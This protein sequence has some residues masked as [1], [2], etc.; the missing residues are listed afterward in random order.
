MQKLECIQESLDSNFAEATSE[1]DNLRADVN[2]RLSILKNTTD[3]LKTS[4]DAAWVEIEALKQQD[5]QNKLQ[6][7]ELEKEKSQLQAEVSATQARAIKLENY[8][9]RENIRLLNV[10][11]NQ[12]ENCKEIVREVMAAV[13]MEG[14]NKVECHAV[15]R[16]GKQRDDGK[17]RAIIARFVNRETRNDLWY[18]R[19]ELANSPNHR[20]VILVPDYAYETAKEQKKLSNALRNARR[21][22][23]TPAYIKNGRIF[24]QGNSFPAD[25][26]LEFLKKNEAVSMDE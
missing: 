18:R 23:L 19:K 9:K 25:N 10:P 3:D 5:E 26:I 1:I 24:V 11:E 22:N 16:T 12:D 17:P 4:L 20:H 14:A 13:K 8:T 21:M 7:A 2:A 15:H 6:L